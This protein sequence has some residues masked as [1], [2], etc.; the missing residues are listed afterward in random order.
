MEKYSGGGIAAAYCFS[1]ESGNGFR[2]EVMYRFF[3]PTGATAMTFRIIEEYPAASYGFYQVKTDF[4]QNN[5]NYYHRRHSTQNS[6]RKI[7]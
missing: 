3:E 6:F 1:E 5:H 4:L 2:S 7:Y